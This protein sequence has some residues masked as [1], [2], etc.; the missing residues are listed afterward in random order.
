MNVIVENGYIAQ[1]EIDAYIARA[2]KRYGD[3]VAVVKVEVIDDR[4]TI[5]YMLENDEPFE[6]IYR[7]CSH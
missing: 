7:I 4:A 6:R 2:Y 5:R 3:K 1:K